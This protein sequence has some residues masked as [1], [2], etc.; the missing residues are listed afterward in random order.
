MWQATAIPQVFVAEQPSR[1]G[2][3]DLLWYAVHCKPHF[4][5]RV[6]RDF[7]QSGIETYLPV[8]E[9]THQWTDRKKTVLVP[10]FPGYVLTRFADVAGARTSIL[11]NFG[12]IRILGHGHY[13]DAIPEE[14]VDS[15]RR[16]LA[17]PLR[18]EGHP[19]IKEGATVRVRHGALKGLEGLMVR[20][21]N[22][23]RLVVSVDLLG[24]SISAEIDSGDVDVVPARR[25]GP[26]N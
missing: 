11:K 4:E 13:L 1:A 6:A 17:S 5:F 9:E 14:Q 22:K 16:L 25:T 23:T 7:S 26:P 8:F 3:P 12:V 10:V 18:C 24:R 2:G 19:L 20:F 21:K 15:V